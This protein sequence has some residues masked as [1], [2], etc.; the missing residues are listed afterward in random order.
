MK[1]KLLT[2]DCET[3]PFL[4][5]RSPEPFLFGLWDGTA[6]AEFTNAQNFCEAVGRINGLAYAHNGGKFDFHFLLPFAKRGS[7]LIMHGR[8]VEFTIGNCILR[9]SYSILPVPLAA[10]KKDKI[11]YA[12]FER[13]KRNARLKEISNYLRKDCEY[14]YE[15]VNAFLQNF[16]N[17]RTIAAAAMRQA[18]SLMPCLKTLGKSNKLFYELLRPF[19]FGGRTQAFERGE[20]QHVRMYDIVSSYPASMLAEHPAGSQFACDSSK[21]RKL[22]GQDFYVIDATP[23][24]SLPTRTETGLE[25]PNTR[26][27]YYATGHEII[28]GLE[29]DTL[30]IHQF[31]EHIHFKHTINFQPYVNRFYAMKE[32][33]PKGSAQYI[34]AK[35]L[36]NSLY[37]KFAANPDLYNEYSLVD[38][39]SLDE[40]SC[41]ESIVS[42]KLAIVSN[43]LPSFKKVWYNVAISASITGLAR[44]NLWRGICSLRQRGHSVYYCDT[45]SIITDGKLDES[46]ALGGWK[47]EAEGAYCAIAR[48]KLYAFRKPDDTWK[49]ASKGARLSPAEI[50]SVTRGGSVTWRNPAPTFHLGQTRFLT[51]VI[52]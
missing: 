21:P 24:G 6:Y 26:G 47:L 20:F 42:D 31:L 52:A 11:D 3:D 48:K 2:I 8:I 23:S 27:T 33:N 25:F 16:G 37:G 7:L 36:L 18:R 50:I 13:D 43:P 44:A 41:L 14:L 19:Y 34:F 10:Y 40:N 38:A 51:R 1:R 12:D 32:S 22:R 46:E 5:G 28:A 4:H 30:T 39:D 15:L 29:T 17:V 9:D 35:L 49:T 45:D